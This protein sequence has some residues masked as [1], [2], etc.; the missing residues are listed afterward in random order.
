M[1]ADTPPNTL[2]N[3]AGNLRY[4]AARVHRPT[5]V[6][7]VREVV[8]GA[9]RV[10]A[11]GSRHSFNAL[12]DTTG[13]LVSTAALPR[14]LEI[15]P[16]RG[17]VRV[18]AGLRYAEIAAE[19]NRSGLA[20]AN[21]AS[22]PHLS[23]AGAVATGTHGSGDGNQGL[24]SAVLA[25]ELVDADGGL[26][27]L[28]RSADPTVFPGAVVSLGAL[29]VVTELTLAVEPA[30]EVAQQVFLGL[31]LERL[32]AGFGEVFASGYSVSAFT[33]WGS[34][35]A[36]VWV[37]SRTDAGSPRTV[38]G[39][40]PATGPQHP[41][42]GLPAVNCTAQLG[43]PG[44]WHERL[45]HFRAAFTPSSGDELQSEYLLPRERAAEAVARLRGLGTR[46][47]PALHTS[48]IR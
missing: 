35:R 15:A 26:R 8:R 25:L 27:R 11:L 42:A 48:E 18:S 34:D 19:L 45:P 9:G 24:A 29:G 31:D 32:A 1:P 38:A 44:P 43:E 40:V 36:S 3:W 6:E 13:D 14:V 46:L 4:S 22:L 39:A 5:S 37:K 12:A 30:Y 16:D 47:A 7:Q 21:L 2:T 41:I 23:V 17:S 28:S 20:L 33:T 10:R